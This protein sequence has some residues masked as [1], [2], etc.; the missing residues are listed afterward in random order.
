LYAYYELWRKQLLI[1]FFSAKAGIVWRALNQNGSSN[2]SDLVKSTSMSREEVYGALAWLGREGK[3]TLKQKGRA[4]IFSLQEAES[5]LEAAK[6]ST[7]ADSVPH[8]KTLHGAGKPPKKATKDRKIKAPTPSSKFE[9][10][11]KALDFIHSEFER[12]H[13][14]TP[15]QVSKEVGMTSRQIGIALSKLD[16]KSKSIN[17]EGES[18]KIYPIDL[19]SRVWELNALDAEGLQK[20]SEASAREKKDNK[21]RNQENFTVFD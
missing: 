15:A 10:L 1:R 4:M 7:I 17:K 12:N 2:I 13:E 14:P 5:C 19:K 8:E 21:E 11:K 3:I 16:I 6:G 20:I 9:A 18:A